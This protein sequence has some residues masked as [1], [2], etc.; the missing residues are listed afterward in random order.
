MTT[1]DSDTTC[2]YEYFAPGCVIQPKPA[3]AERRT[4]GTSYDERDRPLVV[5]NSCID[6]HGDSKRSSAD[7]TYDYDELGNR[8]RITFTSV[9]RSTMPMPGSSTVTGKIINGRQLSFNYDQEGRMTL[10]NK[11]IEQ[12]GTVTDAG[13]VITY[14]A[15]GRRATTLTRLGTQTTSDTDP[16]TG[17]TTF[18][19]SWDES[20]LERYTYSD[21][22][23]LT[24][25]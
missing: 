3:Q 8:T 9:P 7:V 19:A 10:A 6:V 23:Y 18:T 13:V 21:L 22:G 5:I 24:K 14:D 25:I 16:E 15:A 20:H 12:D 4:V 11:A 1:V 17:T 2:S